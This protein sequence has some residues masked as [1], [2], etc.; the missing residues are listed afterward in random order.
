[1]LT[2]AEGRRKL[3]I[4]N[5]GFVTS[6]I[7]PA[8]RLAATA[9]AL[10]GTLSI[11]HAQDGK[12]L[13][14]RG[15]YLARAA[16]CMPC[17]TSAGGAPYAGGLKF[18]LPFGSLYSANITADSETG[19][20]SWT[21]DEF[22]SAVQRGV[23]KGGEHLYPAMPY[24]S[25]SR[26]TRDDVL[27]IKA[28]LFSLKPV[29][30]IPPENKIAAPY[31]IRSGLILWNLVYGSNG[32]LPNDASKGADWNR[33][34]YLAEALGHCAECHTPRGLAMN[35]DSSKPFA[36]ALTNGWY[37]YNITSDGKSG[38]GSWSDDDLA[39]YLSTGHAPGRSSAAGAMGEVVENSLRYLT[40]QDI[41]ALVVYVKS[42]APIS[43]APAV[44]ASLS[45][46][47]RAPTNSLGERLFASECANCH[48]WDG[49]GAQIPHA[50]LLGSRTV[51]DPGAHNLI[52]VLLQGAHFK[53]KTDVFMPPFARAHSND[54]I[55]ALANF[56]NTAFGNGTAR[57]TGADVER[58]R[59]PTQP[60]MPVWPLWL[61]GAAGVIVLI[62]ILWLLVRIFGT[63]NR[64]PVTA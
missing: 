25:Y 41:R 35:L 45:P 23:A 54:E 61:A 42:L 51:N 18:D 19:I 20:G 50:A 39:S 31:N 2:R 55:A 44:T 21:D 17:H 59:N 29:K 52:S 49:S 57:V 10:A 7:L 46:A 48:K 16:D 60:P 3:T 33:G 15:E 34:A 56:V 63:R 38:L 62:I 8:L 22:V 4:K 36:G 40:P 27:A 12:D 53:F 5:N 24:T 30:N 26:L 6:V 14:A 1:M 32:A 43:N 9:T 11:A 13:V 47:Q 37:A 58:V 64:R 28:Y